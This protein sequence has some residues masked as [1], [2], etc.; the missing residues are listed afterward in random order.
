VKIL[1]LFMCLWLP[2]YATN[3]LSVENRL[4]DP[5]QEMQAK[6]LF[7]AIRCVVCESE[8]VADSPSDMAKSMRSF[9]REQVAAGKSDSEIKDYL[10][11]RYGDFILMRPPLKNTTALLWF[12]PFIILGLAMFGVWR[13]FRTPHDRTL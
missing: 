1:V 2:A 4:N 5:N 13:Y 10:V 7:H 8:S 11:S 9:I 6:S 12:G 3:A